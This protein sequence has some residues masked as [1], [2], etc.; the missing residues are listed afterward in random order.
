MIDAG[1]PNIDGLSEIEKLV[2]IIEFYFPGKA[3][4]VR[5]LLGAV[6][7][8]SVINSRKSIPIWLCS[9]AGSGKSSVL[10]LIGDGLN[11]YDWANRG[12]E[13]SLFIENLSPKAF[14]SVKKTDDDLDLLDRLGGDGHR[15]L[16]TTELNP[17][18]SEAG[19]F[20]SSG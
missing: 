17:E 9:D 11:L 16:I 19:R 10:K 6:A 12:I 14:R 15:V 18:G 8:L 1:V 2:A 20:N 3:D 5:V 13:Y 7:S 4:A